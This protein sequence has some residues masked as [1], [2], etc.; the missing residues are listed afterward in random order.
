[1]SFTYDP[2]TDRGKVR[3]EIND[4]VYEQGPL[5]NSQNYQDNE[6]DY[7]LSAEGNHIKRATAAAC[8]SLSQAWSA[9]AGTN[10][11]G[12]MTHESLQASM[13]ADRASKLREQY[14]YGSEDG[15]A[16]AFSVGVTRV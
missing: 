8:E 13:F 9:H 6:I 15:S 7:F 11:L 5:P 12:P 16:K 2:T 1:M 14:G 4:K 3:L 10:R